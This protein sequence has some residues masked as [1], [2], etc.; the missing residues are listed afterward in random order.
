MDDFT[1]E[2]Y[3]IHHLNLSDQK[4]MKPTT[5][6]EDS[7]I[8]TFG[9][10]VLKGV[11][12]STRGQAYKFA[13]DTE[14]LPTLVTGMM[15]G[16]WAVS[17][18]KIA[19]RLL[20]SEISRQDELGSFVE[21]KKGSLLQLKVKTDNSRFIIFTKV[22]H[23]KYM[24]EHDSKI[25]FG[26]PFEKRVQKTCVLQFDEGST[27]SSI[28]I[29]DS[30]KKI[31]KYWWKDFLCC[32][33]LRSP[34]HNTKAAFDSIDGLLKRNLKQQS[35]ADYTYLRNSIITHFRSNESIAYDDFVEDVIRSYVPIN[36]NIKINEIADK[37]KELP[38]NKGFDT[39]FEVD[40]RSIKARIKRVVVLA[41][42]FELNIKGDIPDLNTL[43]DTGEDDEGRY[44]K[45]YSEEGYSEFNRI[46]RDGQ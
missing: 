15:N 20:R 42:N 46:K 31:S 36:N 39:Q 29:Y 25:H 45:I 33:S 28:S 14:E 6:T 21:V 18:E 11:F 30:N 2:N 17:S 13:S 10:D 41:E 32:E 38:I 4:L 5:P 19:N 23:S 40:N 26:L 1:L 22:D 27:P 9:K 37:I 12:N 16:G 43:V 8:E 24:D 3:S 35:K 34:E 44:L 7:D